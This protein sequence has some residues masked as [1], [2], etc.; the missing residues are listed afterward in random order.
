MR[1]Q[2][3]A[4]TTSRGGGAP[5]YLGLRERLGEL[6]RVDRAVAVRVDHAEHVVVERHGR[7]AER[8]A[9]A[10]AAGLE[11]RGPPGG[12]EAA[13][14]EETERRDRARTTGAA[15]GRRRAAS[16]RRRSR[17]RRPTHEDD[18]LRNHR[19]ATSSLS[20]RGEHD[21]RTRRENATARRRRAPRFRARVRRHGAAR[22][23][24]EELD[25][26]AVGGRPFPLSGDEARSLWDTHVS[27]S[28]QST[29]SGGRQG[30]RQ[31]AGHVMT[32][33][34][35]RERA[36]A[37]LVELREEGRDLV[38]GHLD[39]PAAAAAHGRE[40]LASGRRRARGGGSGGARGGRFVPS[41]VVIVVAAR[42]GETLRR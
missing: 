3:V 22:H 17:R 19:R 14:I 37:V 29:V 31:G 34:D 27:Y 7:A 24:L 16:P 32:N 36:V 12:R 21:E 6:G 20:P 23:R 18:G 42:R 8:V 4:S 5:T 15:R 40:Q 28:Q 41:S 39:E 9:R 38:G 25:H 1:C 10:L 35:H 13:K 33:L 2:S 11:E 30:H 26:R